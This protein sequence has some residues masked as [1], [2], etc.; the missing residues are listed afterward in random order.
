MKGLLQ[1]LDCGEA[2]T[3]S[4][5][6]ITNRRARAN[7]NAFR[8]LAALAVLFA[9]GATAAADAPPGAYSNGF[10]IDTSNWFDLTNGGTG[11]IMRHQNGYVNGAYA[12]GIASAAPGQ[13][14]ARLSGDPC[15][16]G[17]S[18]DCEGPFTH[19]GGYND[20]FPIEGYRTYVDIYLD[21]SW[22]GTHP[23]VRFDFS[24]AISNSTGGFLRDFV[25]NAGTNRTIDPGPAG[26][27][28]NASTNA[29]RSGA[30]P[31]N[32]CPS[33]STSPNVCRTP[34]HITTSGWY[35]FR[36]TFRNAGGFLAVDMEIFPLGNSTA[37]ASWTIY[38][39]DAIATVGGNRYGWFANEEIPDLPID[40]SERTGLTISLTP[41]TATN[42]V[43]T[44]HTVTA[45]VSSTDANGHP[46][47]GPGMTIEFDVTSGPNAGQT[48]H[49]ANTGCSTANCTTDASGQVSWTYTSNG[50][51]GTD[52]IRACFPDRPVVVQRPGD[53]AK[54]CT[55]A[56][57]VWGTSTGK[58]TGG[59]Q[60]QGDPVFSVDGVLLSVPALVPSLADPRSQASFGFVVQDGG[61]P[62][63]NLEYN[64]HPAGVRIKATSIS[65]L[66]ITAGTCGSNTHATFTGTAEVIQSTGTTTESFT[67]QVDDCGEPGTSDTFGIMTTTYSNGPSTLIGGNIQIHR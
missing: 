53:D 62:T 22:A 23:D 61:A 31:E 46:A 35:T 29:F 33:P 27:F 1:S 8:L 5:T 48:S 28:I 36:H 39:G 55:T 14:H 43:G 26:F 40:N 49:P 45:N 17:L 12:S 32:T 20:M 21:A 38:S 19:W 58:V 24:S 52:T 10:E 56:T 59:G 51:Q 63:G 6:R 4:V 66:F 3:A 13:W 34:A 42:T 2:T 7:R 65:S 57:K 47:P 41:A 11:H 9:M 64:D 67:V 60:I 15:L 30:F 50:V 54:T 37:V 16:T 18:Q 44:S 25:F